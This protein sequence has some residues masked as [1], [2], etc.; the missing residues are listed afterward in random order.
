MFCSYVTAVA[1]AAVRTLA[2]EI[3]HHSDF[4]LAWSISARY[5]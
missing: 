3:W 5:R 2:E 4:A 1:F